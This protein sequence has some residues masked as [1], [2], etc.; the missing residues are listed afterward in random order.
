M[1]SMGKARDTAR[2]ALAAAA[3][4]ARRRSGAPETN[5]YTVPTVS[6]WN[7]IDYYKWAGVN[8]LD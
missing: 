4:C 8:I 3:A 2:A 1:V 6:T 5:M 7:V